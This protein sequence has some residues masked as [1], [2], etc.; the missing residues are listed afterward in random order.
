MTEYEDWFLSFD[1]KNW[2]KCSVSE[3]KINQ[4]GMMVKFENIDDRT[5]ADSLRNYWVVS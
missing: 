5:K 1:E 3:V 4:K 2:S